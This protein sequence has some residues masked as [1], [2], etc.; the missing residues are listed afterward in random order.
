MKR[1]GLGRYARQHDIAEIGDAGQALLC[2][3]T[4]LVAGCGGLGGPLLY[5]LAGAGV[6]TLRF[7][8]GDTVARTNLNR[9]FLFTED[10]IGKNK[11]RA[12]YE[13]LHRFNPD[14]RLVPHPYAVT[15]ES[16]PSLVAGCDAVALAVDSMATRLMLNAACVSAGVP[17]ADGGVDGLCG[18]LAT[19]VPGQTPC[20][21]CL[22]GGMEPGAHKPEAFAPVV[23]A[24]AALEAQLVALMLLRQENPL[25]GKLLLFDGRSLSLEAAPVLRQPNCPVCGRSGADV[26]PSEPRG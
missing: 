4:V 3:S 9:Q 19:V 11:A 18:T 20:L 6:G 25:L 2:A 22:Y 21:C 12:A 16:A 7:A 10:D 15:A 1:M 17:L 8:D 26:S 5:A 14:I 13:R 23:T 24:I